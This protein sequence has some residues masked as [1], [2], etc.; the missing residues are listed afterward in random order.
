M[1]GEMEGVT[2]FNDLGVD[3]AGSVWVGA[4]RFRPFGGESP[5]PG[6]VFDQA[7]SEVVESWVE[8]LKPVI[9]ATVDRRSRA[10]AS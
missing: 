7:L 2:G 3:A 1:L 6:E 4:L 5:V 9:D 10:S 8:R